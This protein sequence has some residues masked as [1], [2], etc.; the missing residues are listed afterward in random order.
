MKGLITKKTNLAFTVNLFII[1]I[2][3]FCV[4]VLGGQFHIVRKNILN[5]NKENKNLGSKNNPF[6]HNRRGAFFIY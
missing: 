5:F 2:I 4:C 6:P 3:I 1:V